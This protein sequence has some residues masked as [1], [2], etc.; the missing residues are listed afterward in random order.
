MFQNIHRRLISLTF[1]FW[2][3]TLFSFW[4]K[5]F[6]VKLFYWFIGLLV[7]LS[8]FIPP[9]EQTNLLYEFVQQTELNVTSMTLIIFFLILTYA[10]KVIN[11]YCYKCR[12]RN[13]HSHSKV[14]LIYTGLLFTVCA[15]KCFSPLTV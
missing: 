15:L 14:A 7:L 8:L 10:T 4:C 12:S 9:T 5:N 2:F 1:F 6:Y 3:E 11:L 13:V